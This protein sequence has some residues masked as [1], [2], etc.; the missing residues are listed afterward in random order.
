MMYRFSNSL[1]TK[2]FNSRF[3][4]AQSIV[5]SDSRISK[6]SRGTENIVEVAMSGMQRR[7]SK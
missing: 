1:D 3:I 6:R 7:R 4:K 2:I 5:Q